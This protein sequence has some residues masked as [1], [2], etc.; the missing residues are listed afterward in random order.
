MFQFNPYG[1]EVIPNDAMCLGRDYRQ[2]RFPKTKKKRIRKKWAR[3]SIN[4][5]VIDIHNCLT[6]GNKMYVTRHVF[7]QLK[8]LPNSIRQ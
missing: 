6:I 1:I 4:F 8:N 5:K 2:V 7:N 3:R